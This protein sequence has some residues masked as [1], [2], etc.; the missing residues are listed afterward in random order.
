MSVFSETLIAARASGDNAAFVA[1]A[2]LQRSS[3]WATAAAAAARCCCSIRFPRPVLCHRP[4]PGCRATS[5]I[6]Y[7]LLLWCA[8]AG[9]AAAAAAAGQHVPGKH[10]SGIKRVSIV[11]ACH[12][13]VGFASG[14]PEPGYD[15]VVISRYFNEY[16]PAAAATGAALRARGG[17]ERLVFLTHVRSLGGCRARWH[18]QP[19]ACAV[20]RRSPLALPL[21]AALA[22]VAGLSVPGLPRPYRHPVPQHHHRGRVQGG[23]AAG[24]HHLARAA[25]QW[26]G[27]GALQ[28]RAVAIH[29]SCSC[30]WASHVLL[31]L[32]LASSHAPSSHGC[33]LPCPPPP[34]YTLPHQS[35]HRWSCMMQTSCG[36]Q[37]SW[38]MAWTE[39]L[40]CRPRSPPASATCRG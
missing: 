25:A 19:P 31:P 17:D 33:L 20:K 13:D 5:L 26:P 1:A 15:N 36:G 12:L 7:C 18:P 9:C 11:F 8:L 2:R 39:T 4:R 22:V 38:G 40:A 24:G 6:L 28:G 16:F 37:W 23:G 27:A 3:N 21:P 30:S 10:H 29:S 34:L 14:G 35:T 32:L